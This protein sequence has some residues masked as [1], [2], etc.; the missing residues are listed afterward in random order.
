MTY[1]TI[2]SPVPAIQALRFYRV[3]STKPMAVKMVLRGVNV[4]V[5]VDAKGRVYSNQIRSGKTYAMGT[6]TVTLTACVALGLLTKADLT[7]HLE[8]AKEYQAHAALADAAEDYV[9][10]ART[11]GIELTPAQQ[12]KVD[13]ALKRV[14][15]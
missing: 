14:P 1:S 9:A 12:E 4:F 7:A 11:L 5:M 2:A 15:A 13:A 6:H 10:R 8:A 3:P